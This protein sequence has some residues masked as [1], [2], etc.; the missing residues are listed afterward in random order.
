MQKMVKV[1]CFAFR[2]LSLQD[3]LALQV[4]VGQRVG[5]WISIC[6]AVVDRTRKG[7]EAS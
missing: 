6:W 7:Y 1:R 2:K 3:V 5:V 4:M